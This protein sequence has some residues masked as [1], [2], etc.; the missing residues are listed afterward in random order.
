MVKTG[1]IEEN[2][3]LKQQKQEPV[4]G[5]TGFLK[6]VKAE[7]QYAQGYQQLASNSIRR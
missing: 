7:N 2:V 6:G 3:F 4:V 1:K 5:Y